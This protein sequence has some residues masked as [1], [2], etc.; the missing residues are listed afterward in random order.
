ML[1]PDDNYVHACEQIAMLQR[2][3][4]STIDVSRKGAFIYAVLTEPGEANQVMELGHN[5]VTDG[6][7]VLL[8]RLVRD[9]TDPLGG[10]TFGVVGTGPVGPDPFTPLPPTP[11][12]TTLVNEIFRKQLAS[13][14]F[15]DG[16]GLPTVT[17]QPR[18]DFQMT[19]TIGEAVGA[20]VE[21]GLAGGDATVA[22]NSGNLVSVENIP[23]ISKT[24]SA[25]L[26]LVFRFQF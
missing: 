18:V 17:P 12:Q 8:A 3:A 26:T 14:N 7:G 9:P 20:I 2:E 5:I 4:G 6:L 10:I 22:A 24:A 11:S 19:M 21:I 15:V 23:V 13:I 1:K 16:A 25:T